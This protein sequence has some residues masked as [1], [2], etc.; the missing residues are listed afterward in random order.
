MDRWTI[1]GEEVSLTCL[2]VLRFRAKAIGIATAGWRRLEGLVACA[3][4]LAL[5]LL[6]QGA[7]SA[8]AMPTTASL[9]AKIVP[10]PVNPDAAHGPTYP[11]TGDILGAPAA[12]EGEVKF[13]GDEYAIAQL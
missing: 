11:S 10:I 12:F 3:T 13:R 6:A 5:L 4:L 7:A 2:A 1:V 9:R 8:I